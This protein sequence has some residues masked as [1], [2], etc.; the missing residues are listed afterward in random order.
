MLP[1]DM[2]LYKGLDLCYFIHRSSK[3]VLIDKKVV[4]QL[5]VSSLMFSSFVQ[6]AVVLIIYCCCKLI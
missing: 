6:V 5:H 3:F 4:Y 2:L 1:V